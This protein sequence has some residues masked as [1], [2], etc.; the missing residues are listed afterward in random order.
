MRSNGKADA[1]SLLSIT[2]KMPYGTICRSVKTV[3]ETIL[4]DEDGSTPSEK[5]RL[6]AKVL[7]VPIERFFANEA[8]PERLLSAQECLRLW[9]M[10][11]TNVGRERALEC[12]RKV[13]DDEQR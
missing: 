5:L 8:T 1:C 10:I 4:M 6:I 12:L 3:V 2:A 9:S 7:N 13:V 11:K